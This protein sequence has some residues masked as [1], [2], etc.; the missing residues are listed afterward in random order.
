M[1]FENSK[2]F[3]FFCCPTKEKFDYLCMFNKEWK[4]WEQLLMKTKCIIQ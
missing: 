3:I 1:L 4:K 2:S